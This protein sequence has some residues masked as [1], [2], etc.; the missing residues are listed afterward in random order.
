VRVATT[1][2]VRLHGFS[3][4]SFASAEA[5][6]QS[7]RLADTAC[8]IT[9]MRMPG[10]TGVEL[11]SRLIAEGLRMPVIFVTAFPEESSRTAA[12]QAGAVGF[13][14]KPFDSNILID[15]V[16]RAVQNT[17]NAAD[18]MDDHEAN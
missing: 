10:M 16:R 4:F 12:L 8:L 11:Q 5:F 14:S 1:K 2:L 17:S 6:L 13:L 15:C 9:D 3:T 7:P 18:Q